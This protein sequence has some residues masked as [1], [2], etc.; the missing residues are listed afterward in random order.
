MKEG[1]H[2]LLYLGPISE[3]DATD[4]VHGEHVRVIAD[5]MLLILVPLGAQQRALDV[6]A[7]ANHRHGVRVRLFGRV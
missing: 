1:V 6:A 7:H 3:T 2:F 5:V 4:D